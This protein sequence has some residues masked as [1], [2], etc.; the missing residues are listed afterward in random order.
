VQVLVEIL[1]Y[2]MFSNTLCH[3]CFNIRTI[4]FATWHNTW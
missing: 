1:S 2:M 3:C 4:E